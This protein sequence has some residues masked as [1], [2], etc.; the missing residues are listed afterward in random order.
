[1]TEAD[2]VC[3]SVQAAEA[4][5]DSS[6]L[7]PDTLYQPQ[8]DGEP[9]RVVLALTWGEKIKNPELHAHLDTGVC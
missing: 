9:E 6:L 5:Y 8:G 3:Q 4:W 2:S 1:M 7:F